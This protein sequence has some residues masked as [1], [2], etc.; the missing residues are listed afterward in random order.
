MN[1]LPWCEAHHIVP[2]ALGGATAVSNGVLLAGTTTGWSK[3]ATGRWSSPPMASP[4]SG[5]HHGSTPTANR[6]E[7]GCT[8]WLWGDCGPA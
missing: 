8:T 7:T 3:L 4:S 5:H 6:C 2:W 1:R